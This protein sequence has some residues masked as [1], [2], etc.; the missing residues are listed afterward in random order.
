MGFVIWL[1]AMLCLIAA[2]VFFVLVV[3][4]MFQKAGA[5]Q[6]ILGI[7]TCGIWTY[8]WGWMNMKDEKFQNIPIM[9]GLT[10]TAVLYVILV[11]VS[12]MFS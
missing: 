8:I 7:I 2:L 4:K 10:G 9:W 6:G 3:I 12:A 11:N 1:L 5:V